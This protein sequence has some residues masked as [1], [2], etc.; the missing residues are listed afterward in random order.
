MQDIVILIATFRDINAMI[1]EFET[2]VIKKRDL[3]IIINKNK[4]WINRQ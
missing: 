2:L 3:K 1:Y 4:C